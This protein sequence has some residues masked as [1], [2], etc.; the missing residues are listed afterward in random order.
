MGK[1]WEFEI[2]FK[3]YLKSGVFGSVLLE[4]GAAELEHLRPT[5]RGSVVV[6]SS[7]ARIALGVSTFEDETSTPITHDAK[8][9]PRRTETSVG[10]A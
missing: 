5:I 6:S 2:N 1:S 8:P 3:E 7:V 4:C 10:V 9:R